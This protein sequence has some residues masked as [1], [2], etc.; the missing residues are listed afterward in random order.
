MNL[1]EKLCK[2]FACKSNCNSDCHA[3]CAVGPKKILFK[4]FSKKVLNDDQMSPFENLK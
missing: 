4:I 1:F 2:L 3:S